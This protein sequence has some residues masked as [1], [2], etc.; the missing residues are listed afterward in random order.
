MHLLLTPVNFNPIQLINNSSLSEAQKQFAHNHYQR[1]SFIL[2]IVTYYFYLVGEPVLFNFDEMEKI[3]TPRCRFILKLLIEGGILTRQKIGNKYY[4]SLHTDYQNQMPSLEF[5]TDEL[6]IKKIKFNENTGIKPDFDY[7]KLV[8]LFKKEFN[9]T[10]DV[11]NPFEDYPVDYFL[12]FIY[13]AS[14]LQ[15]NNIEKVKR[16][17]IYTLIAERVIE[18]QDMANEEIIL[19]FFSCIKNVDELKAYQ[20]Q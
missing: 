8:E 19:D 15:F 6:I 2:N 1:I 12:Q 11:D 16:F 20:N 9:I 3:V 17:N 7:F 5:H 18:K 14:S 13:Q 4:Y 10:M